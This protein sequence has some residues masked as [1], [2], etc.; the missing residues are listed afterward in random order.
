[1]S[2][3][4]IVSPVNF[5]ILSSCHATVKNELVQLR[6]S[7]QEFSHTIKGLL[8]K[9]FHWKVEWRH[10]VHGDLAISALCFER[11]FKIPFTL[12]SFVREML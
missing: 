12:A 11:C 6:T 5:L 7:K 10:P 3:A 8:S 9:R 4:E 2:Y 1:M